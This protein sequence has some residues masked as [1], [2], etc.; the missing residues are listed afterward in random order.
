M[1]VRRPHLGIPELIG[2]GSRIGDEEMVFV[3]EI[4]EERQ[5][6]EVVDEARVELEAAEEIEGAEGGRQEKDVVVVIGHE[7][8]GKERNALA[9]RAEREGP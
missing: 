8:I 6:G 2:F 3:D 7:L 5:T 4:D 9:H 1:V